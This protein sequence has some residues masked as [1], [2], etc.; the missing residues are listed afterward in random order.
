MDLREIFRKSKN[1]TQKHLAELCDL[2]TNYIGDIERNRRKNTINAI[3]KNSN[4]S[5]ISPSDL[6]EKNI[7][8]LN[9]VNFCKNSQ[10][11]LVILYIYNYNGVR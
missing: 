4:G 1:L 11:N 5:N 9:I 6:L 3:E 8:T 10:K 7:F 2:S